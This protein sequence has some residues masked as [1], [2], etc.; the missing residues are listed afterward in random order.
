MVCALVLNVNGKCHY[1]ECCYFFVSLCLNWL[2]L[3]VL[4]CVFTPCV[5]IASVIMPSVVMPSVIMSSVITQSVHT[6]WP[7]TVCHYAEYHNAD[8]FMLC[9][10]F[11]SVIMPSVLTLIFIIRF[12]LSVIIL[13]VPS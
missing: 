1:A 6:D 10:I 11:F 5:M 2:L 3:C 7:F 8:C 4:C 13:S 9:V 12:L